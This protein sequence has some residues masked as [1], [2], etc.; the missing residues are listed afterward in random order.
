[1]VTADVHGQLKHVLLGVDHHV[2]AA[3]QLVVPDV[4]FGPHHL[5][6]HRAELAVDVAVLA[7]L[8]PGV[9]CYD[10]SITPYT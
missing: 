8:L 2:A 7:C 9:L 1:M 6:A 10:H 4:Q 3:D 5:M